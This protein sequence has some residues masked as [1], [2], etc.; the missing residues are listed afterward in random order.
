MHPTILSHPPCSQSYGGLG[1]MGAAAVA[2]E[3]TQP[4][5]RRVHTVHMDINDIGDEGAIAIANTM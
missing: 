5:A 1:D 2:L 4:S 3:L